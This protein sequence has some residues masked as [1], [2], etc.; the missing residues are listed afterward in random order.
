M[1]LSLSWLREFTPDEGTAEALGDRL[2]MLGLELEDIRR[3]YDAISSIVVGHVVSCDN[4]PESDHLHVCKVDAGQGE[5]LD[6]VCGAPNVAAGQRVPVALVGT[7][8][9]DGMVIKKAK[10][11]GVESNGMLCSAAELQISEENDGLLELAADAPIGEDVRTYLQLNDVSIEVDLTPNRGDCLSLAGLAR[12][13]G[14][15][16]AAPVSRPQVAAVAAVH[17]QVWQLYA[18][19]LARSGPVATLLER[20]NDIPAWPML[21]QEAQQAEAAAE[22]PVKAARTKARAAQVA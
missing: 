11:R 16:Y 9:P 20:D 21:L 14:A 19:A 18:Y 4:H 6:I 3:P 7:K 5:L 22:K 15:L 1:L 17:E 13:V 10:L 2:T 8:M 12:E